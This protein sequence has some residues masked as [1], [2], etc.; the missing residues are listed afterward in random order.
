MFLS[1]SVYTDISDMKY[2]VSENFNAQDSRVE[3]D[4]P[5]GPVAKTLL[6]Q[7]KGPRFD[8]SSGN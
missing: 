3:G 1:F 7:W 4:F 8:P 6:S 5:S 2:M